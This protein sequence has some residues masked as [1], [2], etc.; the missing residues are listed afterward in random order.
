LE[1]IFL[2]LLF[3]GSLLLL[4]AMGF[5]VA[6]SLASLA[7]IFSYWLWGGS[8]AGLFTIISTS[9]GKL[10]EF[11]I[12]AIPLFIFMAAILQHTG[13]ADDLYELMY[14]LMGSMRGGLG[15]GTVIICAVF[16][17]MAGISTVATAAMGVI[18]LPSMLQRNY[19][20]HLAVG[21]I[22]AGGAL[23]ILIPPSVI[24][25]LYGVEAGVS[26]GKLFMG[27]VF[28]GI[29]LAGIFIFYIGIKSWL[30]PQIA[31]ATTERFTLKEKLIA[32]KSVIYPFLLILSVLGAIYMGVCTP[33]EA[34]A[35]GA[36]GA[37]VCAALKKKL[38]WPNLKAAFAMTVRINAMVCWIMVSAGAFSTMVAVSGLGDWV[39]SAVTGMGVSKWII[40]FFMQL[41]FFLLGMFLDPAGII[42]ITTPIFVPIIVGL[43]FDPLWFGVLFTINM[44]M[45]YV[46]PPFGFNL[47][48]MRAVVPPGISMKDIYRSV[49]PFISLQAAC[50]V[51][52]ILFPGIATWLPSRMV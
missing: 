39:C 18:A 48:I 35:I 7:T 38:N 44:E 2:L 42:L 37:L 6:F 45:A 14:R 31:P 27:G 4:L 46:T 34:A 36:F 28:P 5:P 26:I 23:G 17:A 10:T 13:I 32:S 12:I 16:A 19:N 24:M 49:V 51:I 33:S 15:M 43:G 47:F 30:N 3:F 1:W 41:L 9:Y 22:C 40:L 20:K 29:L 21:S 25:I 11:I 52:V 8:T 50:L